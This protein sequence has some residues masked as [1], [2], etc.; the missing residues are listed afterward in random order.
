M[1]RPGQKLRRQIIRAPNKALALH[2]ANHIIRQSI[3]NLHQALLNLHSSPHPPI[4]LPNSI[5]IP[6]RPLIRLDLH[7]LSSQL[8]H[9]AHEH[10]I[11]QHLRLH[12]LGE[13]IIEDRLPDDL[14]VGSPFGARHVERHFADEVQGRGAETREA[15]DETAFGR[16]VVAGRVEA[17]VVIGRYAEVWCL[18]GG[19]RGLALLREG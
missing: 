9:F 2:L 18:L 19:R 14:I 3:R 4:F 13:S 17:D 7:S 8:P 11:A 16:L 10:R 15:V 5:A 1:I 6:Q 12:L